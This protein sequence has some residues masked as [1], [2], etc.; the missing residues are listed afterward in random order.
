MDKMI[1]LAGLPDTGKTTL[2]MTMARAVTTGGTWLDG[3]GFRYQ[4]EQVDRHPS[5]R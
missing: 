3:G 5:Q 2:A 4:L 1:L